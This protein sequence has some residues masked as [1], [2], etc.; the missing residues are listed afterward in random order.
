MTVFESRLNKILVEAGMSRRDMLRRTGGTLASAALP[1]GEIAKKIFKTIASAPVS[2]SAFKMSERIFTSLLHG[3]AENLNWEQTLEHL[4]RY[5]SSGWLNLI[6]VP[7]EQWRPDLLTPDMVKAYFHRLADEGNYKKLGWLIYDAKDYLDLFGPTL[8]EIFSKTAQKLGGYPQLLRAI[9]GEEIP[10]LYRIETLKKFLPEI[11]KLIPFNATDA[12]PEQLKQI[13]KLVG[14][15]FR[16][17][18]S[19]TE[20]KRMKQDRRYDDEESHQNGQPW[21]RTDLGGGMHQ[22]FEA[23]LTRALL[24]VGR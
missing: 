18:L 13:E 15:R 9:G 4:S 7:R 21:I 11:R 17:D 14:K 22:P 3:M 6:G 19:R 24:R 2:S 5:S 20:T 23:R 12:T 8:Q 10:L 16:T 1:Q